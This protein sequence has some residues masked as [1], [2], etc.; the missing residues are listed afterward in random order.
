MSYIFLPSGS[1][2]M[3]IF[4]PSSP[5]TKSGQHIPMSLD[6]DSDS[7]VMR[8]RRPT[9]TSLACTHCDSQIPSLPSMTFAENTIKPKPKKY[10]DSFY[11]GEIS[12]HHPAKRSIGRLLGLSAGLSLII[13]L[14]QAPSLRSIRRPSAE[15]TLS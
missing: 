2:I 7:A 4:Q 8:V 14:D 6:P 3:G 9:S 5:S 12:I 1:R 13:S 15:I 11:A 10:V